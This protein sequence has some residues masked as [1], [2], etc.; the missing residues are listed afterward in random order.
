MHA[1]ILAY[2]STVAQIYIYKDIFLLTCTDTCD[3]SITETLLR[4]VN[5]P[6]LH[7]GYSGSSIFLISVLLPS[8]I[9]RVSSVSLGKCKVNTF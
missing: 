5:T 1:Y 8:V 9:S 7:E 2:I 6:I 3:R 4:V